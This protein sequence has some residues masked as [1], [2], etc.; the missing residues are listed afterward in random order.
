MLNIANNQFFRQERRQRQKRIAL[1]MLSLSFICLLFGAARIHI[2][3]NIKGIFLVWNLFL[4]WIP[5][6]ISYFLGL[7]ERKLSFFKLFFPLSL[8]LLFLPNAPYIITDLI[9]LH[10]RDGIPM[11]YDAIVI[12]IFAFHGLM[13]GIISTLFVH[14]VL[15]KYFNKNMIWMFLIGSFILTGYGIY[16]G[17]FLRWNSWDIV[18]HPVDLI[19]ES[20]IRLTHPVA[21]VITGIFSL[22][23]LFSY[24]IFYQLIHLKNNTYDTKIV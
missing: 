16:L 17:R 13:L 22:I 3:G 5:F 1:I 20:F 7:R 14:E 23:M 8:W 18:V 15:E 2:S 21:I 19:Q 6:L 24:L 9:H 11:W 4:A 10:P 12:F